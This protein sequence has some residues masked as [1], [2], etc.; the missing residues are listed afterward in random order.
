MGWTKQFNKDKE[1][2]VKCSLC[3]MWIRKGLLSGL[4][5][6]VEGRHRVSGEKQ[7]VGSTPSGSPL[8]L[9]KLPYTTGHK[10][11]SGSWLE[12]AGSHVKAF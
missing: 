7:R 3:R 6:L 5:V 9:A 1:A 12:P 2:R 8:T 10:I 11:R 4:V